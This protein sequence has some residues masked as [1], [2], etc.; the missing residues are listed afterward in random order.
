MDKEK[1]L[2]WQ[3]KVYDY[4]NKSDRYAQM[5][6]NECQKYCDFK[7]QFVQN[8]P[9]DGLVLVYDDEEYT[10]VH[11]PVDSILKLYDELKRKITLDDIQRLK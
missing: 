8:D 1:I 2:K 9:S 11:C 3:D 10:A 4:A 7:I 6:G 5:V